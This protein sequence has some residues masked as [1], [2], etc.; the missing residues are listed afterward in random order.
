MAENLAKW[1]SGRGPISKTRPSDGCGSGTVPLAV[2]RRNDF[3]GF[4][5]HLGNVGLI[6]INFLPE[7]EG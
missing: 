7:S 6:Y 3:H 4:G 2:E 5:Y 1:L